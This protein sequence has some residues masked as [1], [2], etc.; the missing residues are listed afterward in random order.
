MTFWAFGI[1][2]WEHCS[3]WYWTWLGHKLKILVHFSF[4]PSVEYCTFMTCFWLT[5]HVYVWVW[6][7]QIIGWVHALYMHSRH[8][9][10]WCWAYW[11]LHNI[12]HWIL[13]EKTWKVCTKK[14]TEQL[15][16]PKLGK[17]NEKDKWQWLIVICGAMS[18][19]APKR[20]L[21]WLSISV[22]IKVQWIHSKLLIQLHM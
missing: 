10:V 18:Y 14:G 2:F 20:H 13:L 3:S 21:P 5:N 8:P 16:S 19:Q 12:W 22:A 9:K 6:I 11:A 4:S 1:M 15:I 7:T 17:K